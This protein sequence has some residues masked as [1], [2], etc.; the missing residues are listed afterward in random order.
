MSFLVVSAAIGAGSALYG[1]GK[2]ISQSSQANNIDKGN[3]RPSYVIPD[4]YKQNVLAAQNMARVGLPSQQY[5][6]QVNAINRNQAGGLGALARSANP[7]ASVASIVRQGDDANNQL[8]AQDAQAR[9][10]NERYAIGQNAQL[11]SQKLAQQQYNKF[12]NYTEQYNKSAA[13]R[14]AANQNL[15]GAVNG[16]SQMATNL[17]GINQMSGANTTMGQKLGIN[18]IDGSQLGHAG[19]LAPT[20]SYDGGP[21]A[22]AQDYMRTKFGNSN[23]P[24]QPLYYG[25]NW[26]WGQ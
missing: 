22:S 18:P 24:N 17:Y 25:K 20:N 8:N 14:G 11:G 26:N 23:M 21:I 13:L 5:N 4:E 10:T 12:D 19:L 3:P 2:S 7:G 16:A 15:Q 6:N 1:I 9:Q